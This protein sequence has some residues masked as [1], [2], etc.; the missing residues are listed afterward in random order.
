LKGIIYKGHR[1]TKRD[2]AK[3]LAKVYRESVQARCEDVELKLDDREKEM[4]GAW[5]AGGL[6]G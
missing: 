5:V 4:V 2:S 6:T 3:S 1:F